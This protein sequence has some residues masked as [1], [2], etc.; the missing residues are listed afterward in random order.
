M[1]KRS[2]ILDHCEVKS[3]VLV[4]T[5]RTRIESDLYFHF[6]PVPAGDVA[7]NVR[8]RYAAAHCSRRE[9]DH[10]EV[11]EFVSCGHV[12]RWIQYGIRNAGIRERVA[13]ACVGD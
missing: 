8:Y 2:S 12:E 6:A 13:F 7:V 9:H 10:R 4:R 11:F 5:V 3:I 1:T